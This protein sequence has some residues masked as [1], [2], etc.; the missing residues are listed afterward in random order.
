MQLLH[1]RQKVSDTPPAAAY[2]LIREARRRQR[3]RWRIGAVS[4]VLAFVGLLLT[5]VGGGFGGHVP[6]VVTVGSGGGNGGASTQSSKVSVRTEVFQVDE[7][8]NTLSIADGHLVVYGEGA[9]NTCEVATADP[10]TLRLSAGRTFD[11]SLWP[12]GHAT[13]IA[14]Q[15]IPNDPRSNDVRLRLERLNPTTGRTIFGPVVMTSGNASNTRFETVYGG[16]SLWVYGC[17]TPNGAQLVRISDATGVV[18]SRIAMPS[19]CKAIIA[20]GPGGFWMASSPASGWQGPGVFH[21]PPGAK[22]A[23]LVERTDDAASWIL[24]SGDDA[25][26][27]QFTPPE[28][29]CKCQRGELVRFDGSDT[30]PVFRVADDGL[31]SVADAAYPTAVDGGATGIWTVVGTNASSSTAT[32]GKEGIV[33]IDPDTG[34]WAVVAKLTPHDAVPNYSLGLNSYQGAYFDGALYFLQPAFAAGPDVLVRVRPAG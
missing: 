33:R 34:H 28:T 10:A 31:F 25:W 30:K 19:I 9:G 26:I 15:A 3:R 18:Q 27:D 6:K 5:D 16:G 2:V 21:V 17:D 1:D 22:S 20:A 4:I 24:L 12:P 14:Q 13:Y 11:C 8:Y 7:P 32:D 23:A 29:A